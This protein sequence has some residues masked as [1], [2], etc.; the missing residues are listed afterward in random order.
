MEGKLE[1][2]ISRVRSKKNELL[3]AEIE[4]MQKRI[5]EHERAQLPMTSQPYDVRNLLPVNLLQLNDH[6]YSC[7][8]QTP[9]Q[10]V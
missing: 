2:A 6:H 1:K 9:L 10:L 8:D 3:F 4:L 5:A 7:Q